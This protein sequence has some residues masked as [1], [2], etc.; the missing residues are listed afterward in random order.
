MM[1]TKMIKKG[2]SLLVVSASLFL[3]ACATNGSGEDPYASFREN[4]PR[5][6]LVFPPVNESVDVNASYSWLTTASEPIAEQGFYVFPVAIVDEFMKENGLPNPEDMHAA[7]L[8]KIDEIFGA[9]AVLYVTI[10]E[11]GQKFELIQSV[12]KVTARGELVDVKTGQPIWSGRV[13]HSQKSQDNSGAGLLGAIVTAAVAQVG[14]TIND[15]AHDASVY[16]NYQL[17]VSSRRP[18]LLG[19]THPGFEEQQLKAAEAAQAAQDAQ[20]LQAAQAS[21]EVPAEKPTE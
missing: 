20:S 7:P 2:L 15:A 10:E 8:N 19:P 4:M 1:N 13:V 16:A 14:E 9:D 21:G 3:G 6:I 12:T 18:L 11:Y 17:F 5:S